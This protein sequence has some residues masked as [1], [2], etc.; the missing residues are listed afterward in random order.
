MIFNH[1]GFV[2]DVG[3][4]LIREIR[5]IAPLKWRDLLLLLL[6]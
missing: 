5:E 4:Q 3:H 6:L 2:Q 1:Q